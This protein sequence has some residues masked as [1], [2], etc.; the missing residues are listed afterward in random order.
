M[1]V[2]PRKETDVA[3]FLLIFLQ[4]GSPEKVLDI[5]TLTI[6]GT[7]LHSDYTENLAWILIYTGYFMCRCAECNLLFFTV[8]EYR[9]GQLS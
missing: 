9:E 2:C 1:P 3:I 8:V 6:N 4:D 7:N 5:H